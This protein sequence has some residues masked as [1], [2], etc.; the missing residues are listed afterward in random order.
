M[1]PKSCRQ[2]AWAA[3]RTAGAV[4]AGFQQRLPQRQVG[5][6]RLPQGNGPQRKEN[7]EKQ[8]QGDAEAGSHPGPIV[9]AQHKPQGT[10]AASQSSTAMSVSHMPPNSRGAFCAANLLNW[11]LAKLQRLGKPLHRVTLQHQAGRLRV[12]KIVATARDAPT[13]RRPAG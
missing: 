9:P 5:S 6:G 10:T 3:S 7:H 11:L 4:D 1:A 12:G 8:D 13:I 2:S